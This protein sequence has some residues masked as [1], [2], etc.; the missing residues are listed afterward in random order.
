M[1]VEN[2]ASAKAVAFQVVPAANHGRRYAEVVGDGLDGVVLVNFVGGGTL[3][4]LNG[5]FAGGMFTG[6]D[7]DDQLAFG[8]KVAIA[9]QIVGFGYCLPRGVVSVG[10]GVQRVARG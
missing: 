3:R 9:V 8:L 6:G 1:D 7:W 10:Q 2:V 4:I 5:F